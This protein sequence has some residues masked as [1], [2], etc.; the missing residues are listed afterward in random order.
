[1]Y[2]A[3]LE[4]EKSALKYSIQEF[5]HPLK[6]TENKICP[7][8]IRDIGFVKFSILCTPLNWRNS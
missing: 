2:S 7:K 1:V 4:K 5:N 3:K 6:K 8:I